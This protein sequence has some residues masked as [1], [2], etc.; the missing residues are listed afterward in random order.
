VLVKACAAQTA[1]GWARVAEGIEMDVPTV[2]S[3]LHAQV[4]DGG[5]GV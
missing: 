1:F 4:F 5:R 2:Q 3:H